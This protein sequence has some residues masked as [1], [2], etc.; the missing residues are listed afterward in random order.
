M[1]GPFLITHRS[2]PATCASGGRFTRSRHRPH[3]CWTLSFSTI[4]VRSPLRRAGI[5]A[6]LPASRFL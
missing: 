1:R 4:A 5:L 2:L 6:V 3:H